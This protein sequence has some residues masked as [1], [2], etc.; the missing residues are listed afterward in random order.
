MSVDSNTMSSTKFDVEG[1]DEGT[2]G[3]T[4]AGRGIGWG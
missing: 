1:E 2:L 4:R 3:T